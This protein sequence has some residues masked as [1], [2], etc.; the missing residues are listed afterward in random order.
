MENGVTPVYL[1]AQE[2]HVDVL[3]YLV[4]ECDGSLKSKASDGMAPI[5]AAAQMGCLNCL[6]YIIKEEGISIDSKD[7]DEA[8]PLHFAASK[9][10]VKTVRW[11]LRNGAKVVP[12]KFGKTALDDAVENGHDEITNMLE[13]GD[14]FAVN[15]ESSANCVCKNGSKTESRRRQKSD[16]V[17][18]RKLP[19]SL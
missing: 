16:K 12:D 18:K 9:G 8:T 17:K 3:R 11:L 5:H 10:H 7:T 15:D 6:R 19:I 13:N 1:A 4:T 14:F 2:G